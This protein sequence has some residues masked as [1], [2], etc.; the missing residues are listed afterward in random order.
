MLVL[1]MP[2]SGEIL[3][4]H[5]A[6][7][8]LGIVLDDAGIDVWVGHDPV[9]ADYPPR[10]T[11]D[12]E[13]A[14]VV[15]AVRR[16]AQTLEALVEADL[17]PGKTGN[18]RRSVIW[19]RG[20]NVDQARIAF[21]A[22]ERLRA[23]ADDDADLRPGRRILAGLGAPAVWQQS[24]TKPHRGASRLDGVLGNHTSDFVRGVL[25]KV[26]PAAAD[27]DAGVLQA[28]WS[29]GRSSTTQPDK[30]GWA[31]AGTHLDLVHQWL[32]ALGLGAL[33]VGLDAH[34]PGRTPCTW[35]TGTRRGVTLPVL[36]TPIS[37]A[38]LRGVLGTP[39]LGRAP[40]QLDAAAVARLR[41][42][43][44]KEIVVFEQIDGAGKSSVAF[45]FG[46]GARIG[47]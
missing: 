16:S 34:D 42:V 9:A 27:A 29:E 36:A 43:G 30:T 38:R 17:V 7:I 18:D 21:A 24:G 25:R 41:A 46:R 33:P 5:L 44:L 28:A 32:A 3:A 15:A 47:L 31:P 20:T 23:D 35:R 1:R 4:A 6:A 2:L 40:A 14:D 12:A 26:R 11:V 13:I 22:R 39:Q 8:G 10:V 19:A 37:M 45:T